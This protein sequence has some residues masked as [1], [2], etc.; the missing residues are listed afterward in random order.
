MKH[1]CGEVF[2]AF[3]FFALLILTVILVI[4]FPR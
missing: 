2:G 1:D 3:V 4:F